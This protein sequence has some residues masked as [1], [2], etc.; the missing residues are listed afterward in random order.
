MGTIIEMMNIKV[1]FFEPG[2]L[3][4]AI[5]DQHMQEIFER[6]AKTGCRD[7]FTFFRDKNKHKD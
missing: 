2:S 5:F 3:R 6:F 4:A 7:S 1:N